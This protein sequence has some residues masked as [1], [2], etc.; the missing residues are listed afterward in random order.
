MQYIWL[1]QGCVVCCQILHGFKDQ[2]GEDNWTK[3]SDQ[4]PP[5]LR[6]RLAHHYGVW[7]HMGG[8]YCHT[9]LILIRAYLCQ[10]SIFWTKIIDIDKAKYMIC[11]YQ[12][13]VYKIP[14]HL[15]AFYNES[16]FLSERKFL[17]IRLNK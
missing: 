16:I 8:T 15:N 10:K 6:E 13:K 11:D 12:A 17:N 2:V 1:S 4:F 7:T 5:P 9:L 3:F 14:I